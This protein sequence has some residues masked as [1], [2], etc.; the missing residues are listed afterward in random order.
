MGL[1]DY[2][3]ATSLDEDYAHV[4]ERRAASGG[5]PAKGRPGRVALVA[6]AVFGVLVATAAVQTSRNAEQSASARESL[7]KQVNERKESLALRRAL[8]GDLRR[9]VAALRIGDLEATRQGRELQDRLLRLG[10][11]TGLGVTHGPGIQVVVDD[12]PGK[13]SVREQ[14]QAHDLQKL[15]NGLW[16]VG[17]EAIS[18]NGQ[19]LTTLSSIRDAGEAITVNYVSLRPPYVVRA[20]GDPRSMGA[21]LLDTAGGQAWVTLQSTF[22]LQ[23][24]IDIKDDMVL[25]PAKPVSLR[26]AALPAKP[27]NPEKRR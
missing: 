2:L 4:S 16:Q 1:L 22:G 26:S 9:E 19:R 12:A 24:D 13:P 10:V 18:I 20:I 3:T 27:V 21:A 8:V 14:V 5:E 11:V 15:V 25:P 6:L 7:I 23:F 17:A